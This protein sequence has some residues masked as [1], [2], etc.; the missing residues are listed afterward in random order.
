LSFAT[1]VLDPADSRPEV[2]GPLRDWLALQ[3]QLALDPVTAA[4]L[5]RATGCPRRALLANPRPRRPAR[6]LEAAIRRL[7]ETH[8]RAIPL[9]SAA[10][11]PRLA[12]LSDPAPLLLVR[13]DVAAL[14]G[15]SVAIVGSRA[16]TAYG[17]Q[18]AHAIARDL[19]RAGVVV[20]SGLAL[21]ID[22]A[23]H[24]G[25]L[26]GGGRTVAVL[27]SGPDHIYPARHRGLAGRIERQGAIVGELSPGTRPLPE[28]FPLRN[29]LISG[30]SS[31][32]VVV[33]A[34]ERSGSLITAGH[35][36]NQG[37][38]VFAVPGPITAPA[39]AGPNRLLREGAYIALE[40]GD[41][42]AELG[43]PA[44]GARRSTAASAAADERLSSGGRA[45]LRALESEPA[46]R[47]ELGQ[48][49]ARP[50]EQL[51]LDLLELELAGRVVEE[52]DGRLRPLA[53]ESGR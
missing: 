18:A 7:R 23:A 42:L 53:P 38:D 8:T 29:R 30:L 43:I 20:V 32:V 51:A 52:R 37:V 35:A 27:A 21:G 6:D 34:R 9:L 36:A 4:E 45:I 49:L 5:L 14:A 25:A 16:A 41:V 26:E 44:A 1:G 28:F 17:L 19:A 12:R 33:E 10:Y 47:D 48:R 11:P 50:P 2:A 24:R 13:G 31:A 15:P 39:S 46:T 3:W 40:A 22:G